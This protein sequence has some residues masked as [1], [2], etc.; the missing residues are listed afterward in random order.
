MQKHRMHTEVV[1]ANKCVPIAAWPGAGQHCAH[2]ACCTYDAA[3]AAVVHQCS[4]C[5]DHL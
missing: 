4:A 2:E 5:M 1:L 3:A